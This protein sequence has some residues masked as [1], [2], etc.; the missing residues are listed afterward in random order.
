VQQS[1]RHGMGG[2]Q[3]QWEQQQL[4]EAKQIKWRQEAEK[5]ANN[6]WG[7]PTDQERRDAADKALRA[8][9]AGP[10][11]RKAVLDELFPVTGPPSA[12]TPGSV[13][14]I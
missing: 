5:A 10:E 9:G 7:M 6:L 14:P 1:I 13:P 8:Q 12:V 2:P 3:L 11:D 4:E